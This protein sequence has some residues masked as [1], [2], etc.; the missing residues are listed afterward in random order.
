MK[1]MKKSLMSI[2]LLEPQDTFISNGDVIKKDSRIIKTTKTWFMN[3]LGFKDDGTYV[4]GPAVAEDNM[5]LKILEGKQVIEDFT[6]DV[7]N[8]FPTGDGI[9]LWYPNKMSHANVSE[10][11]LYRGTYDLFRQSTDLADLDVVYIGESLGQEL[12]SF[13]KGTI[14]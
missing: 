11:T 12:G 9:A 5:T 14:Q 3:T 8:D 6:I 7:I 10:Y 13:I 4:T 1:R 2:V